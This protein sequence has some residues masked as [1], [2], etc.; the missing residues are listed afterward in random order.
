MNQL[1]IK[2]WGEELGRLVWDSFSD[3]TYFIFN[4]DAEALPDVA[5]ITNPINKWKKELPIYGDK[6]HIYQ[7]LPPFIADSLPDSWG[8]KLF[9]QWVKQ[10]KISRSKVTPLLKLMFIG[11]R[12]MGALEFEPAAQELEHRRTIDVCELYR[13][14]LDLLKARESVVLDVSKV[15]TMQALLAVGTSA[16]GRQMKAVVAFNPDTQEIRSGQGEA[17]S[18]FD[19]FIIKFE[20]EL[21][22]TTEIEMTYYEMATASGIDMEFCRYVE[23]E[24]I[25]HFMTRRF[26]RRNGRKLHMQTL[27]AINPEANSYE[28]LMATCRALE[29]SEK[30]MK[31]VFR[32]LVFN[33]M[34]NNTDD[35]NK[36]FSF[37]L[38][39]GGKWKLAPAYDL[40]F[41]FNRYGSGPETYH[42]FSL[43]GKTSDINKEDLLDFAKENN[44]R[45]AEAVISEVGNAL[46]KFPA[47]AEKYKIP[48][49]W[50]HIIQRTLR[51]NLSNFGFLEIQGKILE[52][53]DSHGRN[54]QQL[55]INTNVKGYYH[56][57]VNVDNRPRKRIV[58]PDNDNFKK[59]QQYEL[60]DLADEEFINLMENLF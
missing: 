39:K 56:I 18:G 43:Y 32:R 33:V 35:H 9:D 59:I 12:G 21:V 42:I 27:A 58:R 8:D 40:T 31:E 44:I 3:N 23:I 38:E 49:S 19:Y 54:F 14:S 53:I 45:G 46:S 15:I 7:G 50:R 4:P 22:P 55:S 5:P 25:V 20:D 29:L 51:E 13:L 36:N 1:T 41:V 34:A 2:L 16:G 11:R 26:D 37:L 60:G 52:F 57:A 48:T 28:D 47:L 30:E 17:P 10:N 24:G 6:R